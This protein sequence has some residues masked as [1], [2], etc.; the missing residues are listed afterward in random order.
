LILSF[1]MKH[2]ALKMRV[3]FIILTTILYHSDITLGQ[4]NR[5]W[6]QIDNRLFRIDPNGQFSWEMAVKECKKEHTHLI[7]PETNYDYTQL[8][9]AIKRNFHNYSA[10]WTSGKVKY[11]SPFDS[12]GL[13]RSKANQ[14]KCNKFDNTTLFKYQPDDCNK[15]YGP[16]HQF[17]WNNCTTRIENSHNEN[18]QTKLGFICER[19]ILQSKLTTRHLIL[20]V[21]LSLTTTGAI[22][23]YIIGRC[24][25]PKKEKGYIMEIE[26]SRNFKDTEMK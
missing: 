9:G 24:C 12:L 17:W 19:T 5:R 4:V 2:M 10:F 15:L 13:G 14:K 1:T 18:H 25:C 26:Y 20:I 6:V 8:K 21:F 7:R 3:F 22:F 23:V 16:I 11:T